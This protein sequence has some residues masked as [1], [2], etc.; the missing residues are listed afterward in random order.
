MGGQSSCRSPGNVVSGHVSLEY[1]GVSL[2]EGLGDQ[3]K[4]MGVG[5]LLLK[6]WC[7]TIFYSPSLSV[8]KWSHTLVDE[9]TVYN[10]SQKVKTTNKESPVWH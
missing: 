4:V 9:C 3:L 1:V 10:M 5:S 7:S 2:P 8:P 6:R